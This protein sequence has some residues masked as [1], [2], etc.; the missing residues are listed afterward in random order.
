MPWA[1]LGEGLI[2]R[3]FKIVDEAIRS[4]LDFLDTYGF[5]ATPTSTISSV[6][7]SKTA[8]FDI[9]IRKR[10]N[11]DTWKSVDAKKNDR[12]PFSGEQVWRWL[13]LI[14][15]QAPKKSA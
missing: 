7:L 5:D 6:G 13:L 8:V 14:V 9:E 1:A 10:G 4:E 2:D 15:I 12:S 3:Q 11:V